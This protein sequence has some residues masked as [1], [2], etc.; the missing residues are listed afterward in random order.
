M[1]K[2]YK[3]GGGAHR[4]ALEFNDDAEDTFDF[5]NDPAAYWRS[6]NNYF[7][8]TIKEDGSA[9]LQ[10]SGGEG[11]GETFEY[12]LDKAGIEALEKF[13]RDYKKGGAGWESE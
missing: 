11:A 1:P 13:I 2:L 6:W 5:E 9:H 7:C 4:A 8:L 10:A 3:P 12:D